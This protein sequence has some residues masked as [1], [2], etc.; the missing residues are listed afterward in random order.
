MHRQIPMLA[1]VT[2]ETITP[3]HIGAG[4]GEAEPLE[5]NCLN[6]RRI[7]D[8]YQPRPEPGGV[9][10]LYRS[11][12][13]EPTPYIPGSTLRGF[14]RALYTGALE[15]SGVGDSEEKAAEIFGSTDQAGAIALN[16]LLPEGP[17]RVF[18]T[19]LVRYLKATKAAGGKAGRS[20]SDFSV[21]LMDKGATFIGQASY[22][23]DT[24]PRVLRTIF[25]QAKTLTKWIRTG[26]G[27]S[28]P[29]T[30]IPGSPINGTLFDAQGNQ[31]T[32]TWKLGRYAKSYAKALSTKR[33]L[34][35]GTPHAYYLV[36]GTD[37]IPGW[38]RV[39]FDLAPPDA[40]CR[41]NEWSQE[42]LQ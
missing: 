10:K 17:V 35:G 30:I 9:V 1:R 36:Q 23:D 14:L 15:A 42:G 33:Q 11:W 19:R 41:L 29:E 18:K 21:E 12:R 4:E 13:Y 26:H 37:D 31:E 27:S 22:V 20:P 6:D 16:D 40:E 3:L 5:D 38:V 8:E 28:N 25:A 7:P 2:M 39:A 34:E 24:L 32:I